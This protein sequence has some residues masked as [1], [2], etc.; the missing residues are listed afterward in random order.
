M[1]NNKKDSKQDANT[2]FRS[3]RIKKIQKMYADEQSVKRDQNRSTSYSA[4]DP[5]SAADLRDMLDK[6][7]VNHDNLVELSRKL[8]S[9]NPIYSSII[10]YLSNM[11]NWRYKVLPH[12]VYSKSKAKL[13]KTIKEDDF[14]I[15]YNTMLEAVDGLSIETKF[16]MLLTLLYITGSVYITTIKDEESM[17]VDSILLP[18][19]YCKKVAET[20]YG[21]AIIDFDF[22]YFDSLGLSAKD[23][24][25]FFKQ[26]PKEFK[27]DY[28]RYKKDVN[29]RW[30]TL[31]PHFSSG[32]LLNNDAIPTL[33]YL[34]GGILDYEKY[35][36]NELE[37][38][39]NTLK[40]IVAHKMPIYQDQM[41]FEMD[42]VEAIH[43]SIAKVVNTNT[44]ARLI[45]TF[46]DIHIEKV[47]DSDTAENQVLSKAFKAIFNDAGFNAGMFTSD[48][49]TA[50]KMSLVRDKGMVWYYVQQFC[51]FY[52]IAINNWFDFKLYEADIDILPISPYTYNDDIK[53]YKDNATLGVGK[54]DYLIASGIKQKNI[55]DQLDLE[56][57]LKLDEI[58]PMQTSYT[59]TA[60]DRETQEDDNK[61]SD[62]DKDEQKSSEIDESS[63]ESGI[64]PTDQEEPSKNDEEEESSK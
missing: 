30:Q 20:Q 31:D 46:G 36:D 61:S 49:V 52:S 29:L 54:L 58:T 12:K 18:E 25:E 39:E 40:Y 10:S 24:N 35:Q 51:S 17:T 5:K 56:A 47:A 14:Q 33:L 26:F 42:E 16:P 48:S 50:L 63:S 64:E 45:T 7:I 41:V 8:Y 22:S 55:K 27:Q 19:K 13:K 6:G 38:N 53:I 60:V 34:Y 1:A 62:Q 3:D 23:L 37:R 9:I 57:F 11:F 2:Q 28:N 43:K 21:T 15:I 44:K 32:V 59:Q 4:S